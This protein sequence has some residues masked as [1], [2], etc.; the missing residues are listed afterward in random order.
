MRVAVGGMGVAVGGMGVAVGGMGVTVGG[1]GVAVFAAAWVGETVPL[2]I[3]T[4]EKSRRTN[5]RTSA[6]HVAA[7]W[8]FFWSFAIVFPQLTA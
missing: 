1:M 6:N 4:I 3:A 2:F 7:R 8:F 5:I